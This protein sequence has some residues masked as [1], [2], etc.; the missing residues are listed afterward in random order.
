MRATFLEKLRGIHIKLPIP[1]LLCV[2]VLQTWY[3]INA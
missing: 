3:Q 1:H 2:L